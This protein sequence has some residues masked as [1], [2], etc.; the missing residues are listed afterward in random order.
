MEGNGLFPFPLPFPLPSILPS[1]SFS[2]CKP[3][4]SQVTVL[5]KKS[6]LTLSDD[7]IKLKLS[8]GMSWET[9]SQNKDNISILL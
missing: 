2:V 9:N 5:M 8:H 7:A 4:A 6:I 3:I 1:M